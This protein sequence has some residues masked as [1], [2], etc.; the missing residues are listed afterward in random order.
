[1]ALN[2]LLS[3]LVAFAMTMAGLILLKPLAIRLGLVDKPGGRKHHQGNIPLIGG[4]A[5]FFGLGFSLLTLNISLS[6]YRCFIAGCVLLVISGVLD[7]FKEL[8]PSARLFIQFLVAI[9]MVTWG[10]Q[11]LFNLGNLFSF[12]NISLGYAGYPITIIAVVAVINAVNMTDGADGLAG[13]V[14]WI[15]LAYFVWIAYRANQFMDVQII[16]LAL[17][18]VFA[19]LCFN[20]PLYQKAKIFMGDSGSMMLGFLLVWFAVGLSQIPGGV[21][22]VTFLWILA[23]P[24]WD[25]SSVVIRRLLRGYSPMKADRGHFHHYLFAKGFSS[26]QVTLLIGV[27]SAVLG[28][29][30]MLGEVYGV[31]ESLMFLT[32]LGFFALYLG[33]LHFAWTK[34]S[35]FKH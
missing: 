12:G 13:S 6:N 7:D 5:I 15:E 14:A 26:L 27:L 18:A 17:S 34:L 11:V 22:P 35:H 23:V 21:H 8:T 31:S 25:I 33:I 32:F 4:I 10:N 29:I 1:M 30:G 20:F 19:F 24:L 3:P 9:L 16:G 2:Y 28:L